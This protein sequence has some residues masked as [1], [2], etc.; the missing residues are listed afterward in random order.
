[1][2]RTKYWLR[3][4]KVKERCC[5]CP[6]SY[7]LGKFEYKTVKSTQLSLVLVGLRD[8]QINPDRRRCV[9][10]GSGKQGNICS[11]SVFF[12]WV[13]S[14]N[15]HP[16]TSSRYYFLSN[17]VVERR[18]RLEAIR[19]ISGYQSCLFRS[20]LLCHGILILLY[21]TGKQKSPLI[22]GAVSRQSS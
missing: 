14:Q 3:S 6:E 19:W 4:H 15:S 7:G 17:V 21:F 11:V 12:V 13:G 16:I 2:R 1:M 20:I 18:K 9:K 22:K 8:F 10:R 5:A